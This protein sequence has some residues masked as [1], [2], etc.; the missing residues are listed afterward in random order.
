MR[1]GSLSFSP[2]IGG[3]RGFL[4]SGVRVIRGQMTPNV[5]KC[6]RAFIKRV[7]F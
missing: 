4:E 6:D 1:G 3:G 7:Y 5:R 2:C